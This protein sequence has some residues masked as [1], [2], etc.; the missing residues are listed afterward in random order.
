MHVLV[1]GAAG[2]VG[3]F[4]TR[5]LRAAGHRVR[6]FDLVDAGVAADESLVGDIGDYDAMR[7]AIEGV[8]AVV[9]LGGN[10]GDR[11][12]PEIR[13]NNYV[14]C[15]NAFEGARELGVKRVVFASRAGLLGAYPDTM[16]RTVDMMPKPRGLYDCSKMLGEGFGFLYHS[17]HDQECVSVRIGNFNPQRDQP[18]HPHHL[19]HGDCMRVF[20][21]AVTC[22]DVGNQVV[23]GVSASDWPLYDMEHGKKAIGYEPQDVS[24]VAEADRI[25]DRSEPTEPLPADPPKKVLITG[26]AGRVGSVLVDGLRERYEIRGM[27]QVDMPGLSDTV[28]ANVS[29]YDACLRATEGVDAV[30]HLAGVPSGGAPWQEVLESNFDGTYNIMEAARINGIRRIGFASRAGILSPV[31]K[32]IQR[33]VDM[34]PMPQSYY[35]M[36]KVFAEGLG[37]A[38]MWRHGI[39]FT[40]VR[41]GNFKLERDQPEHPHQLGHADNVRA[42][43]AAITHTGEPYEVVFGVSDSDWPLYDIDHGR[44]AIGYDPQQISHVPE[45]ERT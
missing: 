42:F 18:E 15:Y 43:E 21:A 17:M 44:K 31:P 14:G 39:R 35:T 3:T 24:H 25:F 19:S 41:I 40:S 8:D 20:E 12:W 4:V 7:T 5:G 1:T 23:F 32:T 30:I 38:Y 9:H 10:G 33:R 28:V 16:Q 45:A 13:N 11:P 27:D 36:S 6:S 22:P 29:D 34:I 37:H 2:A 26:A